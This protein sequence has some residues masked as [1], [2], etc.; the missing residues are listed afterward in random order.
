MVAAVQED[1]GVEIVYVEAPMP[2]PD[3]N[4]DNPI[5]ED[6]KSIFQKFQLGGEWLLAPPSVTS[7][8]FAG[9]GLDMD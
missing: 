1:D 5:F 3:D 4:D 7:K 8:P 9:E 2:T 6:F